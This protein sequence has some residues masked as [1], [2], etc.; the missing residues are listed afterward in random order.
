MV[1]GFLGLKKSLKLF[2]LLARAKVES[3]KNVDFW[4]SYNFENLRIFQIKKFGELKKKKKTKFETFQ[5]ISASE[6]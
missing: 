4:K 1:Q 3:F 2:V 6:G 5:A